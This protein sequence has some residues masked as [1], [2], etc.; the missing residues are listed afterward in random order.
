MADLENT[1]DSVRSADTGSK[2]ATLGQVKNV[3]DYSKNKITELK[4]DF[5]N[6]VNNHPSGDGTSGANGK[7]GVGILS[8]EQTTISTDDGGV[9]VVTVTKTDGTTSDFQIRN[10]SKG[11]KGDTGEKGDNGI[12]G[13][14][15]KDGLTTSVKVNGVTYNHSNGLI[16]L[17]N[18]P[19]VPTNLSQL[20]NDSDF[21]TKAYVDEQVAN[22]AGGGEIDLSGYVKKGELN[23]ALAGKSDTNHTH[24][25]ND[26]TDKPEVIDGVDGE[27]GATYTPYV[28]SECNLSWTNNKGLPNPTTVNIKGEQGI[29]GI[30]G[31]QGV[32]GEKGEK[33][34]KGDPASNEQ[35]A[36]AVN[37]YFKSN[38]VKNGEDG[39]TYTP[40]VSSDGVISWTNNG[41]LENPEPVSIKGDKGEKGDTGVSGANG[42]DG[43]TPHIGENG[44][45]YI[46][47]TDTGRPSRGETGAAGEPGRDGATPQRGVDYWTDADKTEIK[48]YVDDAI[49]GGV[50]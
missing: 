3:L 26:L 44:N 10:G 13:A 43:I 34:D 31:I 27:N 49:L 20:E 1:N 38:P 23:E 40:T 46:G 30:Q 9:N 28:D 24:S 37:D 18:Y 50:W 19:D 25:F 32:Q 12:D 47:D 16:T 29:Q 41:G 4:G 48:S 33:G 2:L 7:D 14:D 39:I 42:T 45:W 8:V 36:S 11:N 6:H 21:T 22:V 15:G 5:E 35:V 17:P